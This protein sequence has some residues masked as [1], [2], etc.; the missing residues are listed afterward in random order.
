MRFRTEHIHGSDIVIVSLQQ[1][2]VELQH[3]EKASFSRSRSPRRISAVRCLPQRGDIGPIRFGPSDRWH[4]V[5][6][7]TQTI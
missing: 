5:D 6:T 3:E 1:I 7:S 4:F 2:N